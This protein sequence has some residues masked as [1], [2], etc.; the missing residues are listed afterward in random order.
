MPAADQIIFCQLQHIA[1]KNA[2]LLSG[3]QIFPRFHCKIADSRC[4]QIA[5]ETP[6]ADCLTI[7]FRITQKSAE[8]RR[9]IAPLKVRNR[10]GNGKPLLR[11]PF[12]E[13]TQF[14]LRFRPQ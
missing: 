5:V 1:V 6:V 7:L 12:A 10:R 4:N 13:K 3:A 8:T 14:I 9:M 11:T 2:D